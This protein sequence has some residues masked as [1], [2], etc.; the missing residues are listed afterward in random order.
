[1]FTV[2]KYAGLFSN[3][4]GGLYLLFINFRLDTQTNQPTMKTG[5]YSILKNKSL[6]LSLFLYMIIRILIFNE[7]N[8]FTCPIF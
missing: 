5:Y 3:W 1:M 2:Y 7:A 6:N 4:L 8:D